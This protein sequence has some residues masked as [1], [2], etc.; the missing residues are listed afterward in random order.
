L[1]HTKKY[2]SEALGVPDNLHQTSLKLFD[3]IA[4]WVKNLRKSDFVKGEGARTIIRGDFRI[5]DFNFSN[6][7]IQLGVESVDEVEEPTLISMVNRTESRKTEDFRLQTIKRKNVDLLILIAVPSGF[8]IKDLHQFFLT[9]KNEFVE[10]LSHEL[11]HA[12]DHHKKPF[13][14]PR[15]RAEY[16]SAISLNTGVPV[17]DQFI[18]DIYYIS[19]SENLVRPSELASAIQNNQVSQKDFLKFLGSNDTYQTVKRIASFDFENFKKELLSNP[20]ELNYMLKHVKQKSK[21]LSD[22]EKLDI[23]L[24]SVYKALAGAQIK[25]FSEMITHHPIEMIMGFEGEK[26][27]FFK[28]FMNTVTKFKTPDEFF[29]FYEQKFRTIGREMMKKIAKLYAITNK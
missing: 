29:K 4:N 25:N 23:V 8:K 22:E 5:S 17:I 27:K 16:Q 10:N 24:N 11:K 21:N 12:Y 2:I 3:R 14:S 15:Q 9:N 20:K 28:K 19:V 1:F 7:K 26:E 6:V 18:N 13:D